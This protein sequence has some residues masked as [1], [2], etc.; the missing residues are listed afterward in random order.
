M[1]YIN[2]F[3]VCCTKRFLSSRL[4]STMYPGGALES[5]LMFW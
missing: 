1:L 3:K 2:Q 5:F 4:N